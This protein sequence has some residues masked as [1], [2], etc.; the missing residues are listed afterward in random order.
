M[1]MVR[2]IPF[3]IAA[4]G[5]TAPSWAMAQDANPSNGR[6]ANACASMGLNPSEAPYA[7]CAMS[8]QDVVA[9]ETDARRIS[10]ARRECARHGY[11]I[12]TAS[13]A[14]CVLDREEN[15]SAMGQFAA[16]APAP[17]A[18]EDPFRSY[19][20]GD[21]RMSVRR[22]CANVGLAPGASEYAGCVSNL[23]MTIDDSNMVGSD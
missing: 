21:Q 17:V 2:W 14:N 22:A 19:Q 18:A 4:I 6:V 16:P 10:V 3:L 7:F 20:R 5:L 11:R 23:N 9:S 8:L 15:L 12:G 1:N 13:F